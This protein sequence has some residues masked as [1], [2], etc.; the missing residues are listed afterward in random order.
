MNKENVAFRLI[1]TIVTT[2]C[3]VIFI[4]FCA[5]MMGGC[6]SIGQ[7]SPPSQTTCDK[8]A[9]YD[10]YVE[11]A[12]RSLIIFQFVPGCGQYLGP[13]SAALVLVDAALDKAKAVCDLAAK[14]ASSA[15]QT[16]ESLN[17]VYEAVVNFNDL[18]GK[19]RASTK[20]Q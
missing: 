8:I 4:G 6:A 16:R 10:S 18:Y 5:G 15:E 17:G 7:W 14:G 1:I 9:Y 11:A 13:A 19:L 20:T 2:I 3:T 12:Q